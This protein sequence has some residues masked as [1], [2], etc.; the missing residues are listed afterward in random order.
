[1]KYR[2]LVPDRQHEEIHAPLPRWQYGEIR[3]GRKVIDP[4]LQYGCY[5]L[6]YSNEEIVDFVADTVKNNK[7]E[8]G[9]LYM[10][11]NQ[12]IRL[13]H[14]SF[15]FSDRINK[16]S[17]MNTF[18]ALS[19]SDSNEGAV[20]LASAYHHAKGNFHKKIVVG[21]EK[22]YHGSTWLT[23]SIGHDNFM[24]KPFYT[25]DP[26]QSVKRIPRDFTDDC[27]DWNSVAAIVI[28]TC[29][30]GNVMVPPT[31]EFWARLD[32]IRSEYDVLIIIDDIFM[33]GGKTGDYIG[34]TKMNIRP[35]ISTMG[36]AITAGFFPLSMVLYNN[37]IQE[38]LP[39]NFRWEHGF[40]YNFSLPGIASATKYLDILERDNLLANHDNIV[41]RAETIF[42][43][44]GF[45]IVYQF[46]LHFK[47]ANENQ[48]HFYIVPVNATDEYFE[49]L[50]DNLKWFTQNTTR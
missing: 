43:D 22:S 16:I 5:V 39:K 29:S 35:D 19:G 25:M 3:D 15:D 10:P 27:V 30:Y 8:I 11:K 31:P 36:K 42:K 40:T 47:I 28:E 38:T 2:G 34:W 44:A 1:M 33:G 7:P 32:R 4:I 49:A 9:E 12:E 6:G 23:M 45:E 26:Y 21:F 24:D 18:F 13:N 17:G 41:R 46:G 48:K 37:K 20:K 50:R 14:I